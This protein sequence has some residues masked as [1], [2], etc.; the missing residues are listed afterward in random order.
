LLIKEEQ[1]NNESVSKASNEMRKTVHE[2]E[3]V[4]TV[5]GNIKEGIQKVYTRF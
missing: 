5:A 3:A 4:S 2:R 1:R